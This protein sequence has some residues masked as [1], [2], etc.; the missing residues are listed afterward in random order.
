ML[1]L[2]ERIGWKTMVNT[3]GDYTWW[4]FVRSAATAK[5]E[6]FDVMM[7]N[8]RTLIILLDFVIYSS[9]NLY[10]DHQVSNVRQ[11]SRKILGQ[12]KRHLL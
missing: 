3:P 5:Y 10:F 8:K 1:S 2:R 9:N 6:F 12:F 7:S 4:L 11:G